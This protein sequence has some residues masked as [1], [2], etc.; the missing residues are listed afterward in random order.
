[1]TPLPTAVAV[2]TPKG[3]AT[4]RI[5]DY[6]EEAKY[7]TSAKAGEEGE[8]P[9]LRMNN[10]TYS[11]YMDYSNLKYI[12][13]PE[14]N[15]HKYLVKKGDLLFNRTN[16]KELV[17]KTAVFESNTPMIAAG[18]LI[19]VRLKHGASPYFIWGYL[20][21]KHGKLVL[22]N[23][24]KNIVG[25]ANINAQELQNIKILKPDLSLQ[26]QFAEKIKLIEQQKELAKKEL[27]ESEDLFQALLQKAYNGELE[28]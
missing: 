7:G 25:M 28:K 24:C 19:R 21:S 20:N 22:N 3:L 14:S 23:M 8:F 26:N 18:Y 16:S 17:G 4:G 1:M 6:V 10:L 11:G 9:Y 12:D 27:K 2:T 15:I 13:V 5:R